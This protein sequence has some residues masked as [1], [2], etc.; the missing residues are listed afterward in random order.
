MTDFCCQETRNSHILEPHAFK[1]NSEKSRQDQLQ[2]KA[3]ALSAHPF[4]RK[5]RSGTKAPA[6]HSASA[7]ESTHYTTS[8]NKSSG[9][10]VP[11]QSLPN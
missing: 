10:S 8:A 1:E 5:G 4:K 9:Y 11:N 2:M 6:H 3:T 7:P